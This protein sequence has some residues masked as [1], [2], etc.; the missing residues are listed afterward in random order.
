M[1]PPP[2][3]LQTCK[4]TTGP[5]IE[6]LQYFTKIRLLVAKAGGIISQKR[7]VGSMPDSCAFKEPWS[8]RK[9][10]GSKVIFPQVKDWL[11]GHVKFQVT[12]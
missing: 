5:D 4:Y 6:R 10:E 7:F 2:K 12:E 8:L 9:H 3:V 11:S 1:N